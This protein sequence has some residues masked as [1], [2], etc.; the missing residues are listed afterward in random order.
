MA[1]K[2]QGCEV[3]LTQKE[4]A[5]PNNDALLSANVQS[6]ALK[7]DLIYHMRSQSQKNV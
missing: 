6:I 1:V 4:T 2:T 7:A 3:A 5:P